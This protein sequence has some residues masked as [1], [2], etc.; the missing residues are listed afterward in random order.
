[1][2]PPVLCWVNDN[3][4]AVSGVFRPDRKIVSWGT[5]SKEPPW[6]RAEKSLYASGLILRLHTAGLVTVA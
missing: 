3:A 5:G 4:Q 1:M 2:T 6:L